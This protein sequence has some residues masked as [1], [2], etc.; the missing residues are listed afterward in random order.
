MKPRI[1]WRTKG[2]YDCWICGHT[3]YARHITQ[4][5]LTDFVLGELALAKDGFFFNKTWLV[6]LWSTRVERFVHVL[7]RL[8]INPQ[9]WTHHG[10]LAIPISAGRIQDMP[11]TASLALEDA[12]IDDGALE[13]VTVVYDVMIY[14]A[15]CCQLRHWRSDQAFGI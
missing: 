2:D 3:R 14:R 7:L 11:W 15:D 1:C 10:S 9:Y 8:S 6:A 5:R 4:S 13:F 12:W